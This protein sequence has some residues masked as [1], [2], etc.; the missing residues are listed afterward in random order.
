MFD[1]YVSSLDTFLYCNAKYNSNKLQT[2]GLLLSDSWEDDMSKALL[3]DGAPDRQPLHI[4]GLQSNLGKRGTMSTSRKL[5]GHLLQVYLEF[6]FSFVESFYG[7]TLCTGGEG[8]AYTILFPL[9]QVLALG[10]YVDIDTKAG[11]VKRKVSNFQDFIP[12]SV[13]L[14][15]NIMVRVNQL[16]NQFQFLCLTPRPHSS[17]AESGNQQKHLKC[18]LT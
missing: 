3:E 12:S 16:A 18:T 8:N 7:L 10:C 1:K 5:A 4:L 2:Q 6:A 9:P 14:A 17:L 11:V 13:D 15:G